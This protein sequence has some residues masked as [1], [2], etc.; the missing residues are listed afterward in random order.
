MA[1]STT[2]RVAVHRWTADSDTPNR[3][4][5]DDSFANIESKVAIYAEGAIGS[6]PAAGVHGKF[7]AS[8]SG[9]DSGTL[10]YDNG[11]AWVV[12]GSKLFDAST[13][14]SGTSTV[15]LTANGLSGQTANLFE[16]KTN[17]VTKYSIDP[18]GNVTM[19]GQVGTTRVSAVNDTA[20]SAVITGKGAASQTGDLLLLKDSSNATIFKVQASGVVASTF[21]GS[22]TGS[23]SYINTN[24]ASTVANL[25]LFSGAPALEV[26]SNKG[27]AGTYNDFMYLHHQAADGT[28]VSRRFGVLMRVGDEIAGDSSK[29]GALYLESSA[30]SFGN[31]DL[32]LAIADGVVMTVPNTGAI[33]LARAV[34]SSGIVKSSITSGSISFDL[35]GVG[36]LGVQGNAAYVRAGTTAI[37]FYGGGVHNDSGGVPGSGGVVLASLIGSDTVFTVNQVRVAN[38]TG[39]GTSNPPFSVGS[40]SSTNVQL[41]NS[42]VQSYNNSAVAALNVNTVGGTLNLGKTGVTTNLLGSV[43]FSSAPTG[44]AK[45][46]SPDLLGIFRSTVLN[47]VSNSAGSGDTTANWSSAAHDPFSQWDGS[48]N[49]VL[50]ATGLWM[51]FLALTFNASGSFGSGLRRGVINLNGGGRTGFTIG[52]AGAFVARG[53]CSIPVKANSGDSVSVAM[54]VDSGTGSL[55]MSSPCSLSAVYLGP[56]S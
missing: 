48:Q 44:P 20:A 3:S 42:T 30:A 37:Y 32:K 29:T 33:S 15:P 55:G 10:Y 1:E 22:A 18:S 23:G 49:I 27:G 2:T 41:N 34:T 17:A 6:R 11:T 8:T 5:F 7:W 53:A 50:G 46:Y 36:N 16:A 13:T 19:S 35:G 21:F 52:S 14:A 45:T 47:G 38:S 4:D 56:T 25:T 40:L 24:A 28:A 31:P 51:F 12:V 54:V 43:A 39:I 26:Y 9:S